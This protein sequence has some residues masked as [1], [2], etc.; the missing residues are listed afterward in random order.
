[1][2]VDP[3]PA[4]V[5]KGPDGN[6]GVADPVGIA[7]DTLVAVDSATAIA[8]DEDATGSGVT[9]AANVGVGDTELVGSLEGTPQH[10]APR[11]RV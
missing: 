8:V 2:T 3:A 9:L 11:R 7:R 5:G 6:A 10:L 4:S 1:M